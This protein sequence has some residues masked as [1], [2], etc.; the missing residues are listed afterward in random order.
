VEGVLFFRNTGSS[1]N[2][3]FTKEP[4]PISIEVTQFSAPHFADLDGDGVPE[5]LSG[6]K[7]G[8]I[9]FFSAQ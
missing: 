1:S 5:F 6:N 3:Q 8:G 4:L 9:L 7:E 2:P